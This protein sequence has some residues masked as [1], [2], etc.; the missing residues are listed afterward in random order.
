MTMILQKTRLRLTQAIYFGFPPV[1]VGSGFLKADGSVPLTANW[2][3]GNFRID[4][5]N[6]TRWF[7]IIAYGAD[8][9]GSSDCAAAI[10]AAVA[11]AAA[12]SGGVVYFPRGTYKIVST[13]SVTTAGIT[14]LGD[15]HNATN[16]DFE[17]VA[18]ATCF[19]FSA[20]AG[21][22]N[23]CRIY[24]MTFSSLN[25]VDTK[26]AVE[27]LDSIN[28][29]A[30]DVNITGL[31]AWKGGNSIGF[32][33][34]GR[35]EIRIRDLDI[36]DCDMPIVIA[37]NPNN[38][39]LSFDHSS[40]ESSQLVVTTGSNNAAITISDGLAISNAS[41]RNIA[42]VRGG[43]GISMNNT[44]MATASA[45]IVIDDLRSEQGNDPTAYAI[46]LRSTNGAI[47]SLHVNGARLENDRNGIRLSNARWPLV[48]SVQFEGAGGTTF[49]NLAASVE[50]FTIKNS[51][52][53]AA[54][55]ITD[56]SVNPTAENLVIGGNP[57][58]TAH[59]SLALPSGAPPFSVGTTS[60]FRATSTGQI[61]LAGAAI[62]ADITLGPLSTQ[63]WVGG[64]GIIY[65]EPAAPAATTLN[66]SAISNGTPGYGQNGASMRLQSDGSAN[67]TVLFATNGLERMRIDQSG[68]VGIATAGA[69]TRPLDLN[70][71]Q[72]WRGIAAPAVSE[73]NSGT[74]YFDSATNK[75]KASLNGS[76]YVDLIGSGGLTGSG[77]AGRLTYWDTVA[78]VAS[79]TSLYVDA[80]NNRLGLNV[81]APAYRLDMDGDINLTTGSGLFING[82]KV[83]W[84]D[85]VQGAIGVGYQSNAD[86]FPGV[87]TVGVGVNALKVGQG[88]RN[89]ALGTDAAAFTTTGTS[90]TML[91]RASGVTNTTGSQNVLLGSEADVSVN[92]L[93]NAVAIGYQAVVAASDSMV[94]GNAS[95]KVGIVTSTPK[96]ALDVDGAV[97]TRHKD[98]A[99]VNGLNSDIALSNTSWLR[100][101]GPTGA[102][103]VGG[104][105][106]GV[107]GRRLTIF[108]TVAQQM[109]IVNNDG[110]SAAANRITTLT[111]GN[112][113][114][115]AGTSSAS[116]IY[117]DVSDT[118]ILVGTN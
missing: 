100:I 106:L 95:M 54:A 13:I 92:N 76:A 82:T 52:A 25:I 94:L 75:L 49:L 80:A 34:A 19:K 47:Q 113:V 64:N 18:P 73:A 110:S 116:F 21:T 97:C 65:S 17:P 60:Q 57:G 30:Q 14:F 46:D 53:A 61:G 8:P 99:L 114:L 31:G 83:F 105:T 66:L 28:F 107:D 71:P 86:A 96:T 5:Q 1:A 48:E 41:F 84:S 103:S 77:S 93:T 89:T 38:A 20:G 7:N 88:N 102:F 56:L 26:V 15:G 24:G 6:S 51:F 101:T 109:T 98:K 16:I 43:P 45:V 90:N 33:I 39:T 85:S 44:T 12:A 79:P 2:N 9:L 70:G 67:G 72:R 112:V 117:E 104:F 22:I 81:A 27:V 62:D 108:N 91:G 74:I 68:N 111:G 29:R 69:A 115:R 3:A 36:N 42:T 35:Q 4:S 37:P 58:F 32:K 87:E 118:W 63:H 11:A 40:I 10:T 59:G 23:N 55:T 78:S 50:N